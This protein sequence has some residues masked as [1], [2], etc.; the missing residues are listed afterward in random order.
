M[1][2]NKLKNF[3]NKLLIIITFTALVACSKR[4][5]QT[6]QSTNNINEDLK[7]EVISIF[8]NKLE[9]EESYKSYSSRDVFY[10]MLADKLKLQEYVEYHTKKIPNNNWSFLKKENQAYI[11][12]KNTVQ[13][14][15]IPPQKLI[16]N[17]TLSGG[18]INMQLE[19][20][21]NIAISH[22]VNGT[23]NSCY[24]GNNK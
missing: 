16:G 9:N 17:K 20:K 10:E 18:D 5:S 22:T 7:K 13:L 24:L 2:T 6:T 3:T 14:E 23:L 12:C 21:W 19:D 15:V 4:E 1:P 8:S 11:Y